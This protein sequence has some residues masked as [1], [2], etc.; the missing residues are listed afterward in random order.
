M[1]ICCIL[2]I[3]EL[4]WTELRREELGLPDFNTNT[5]FY[6]VHIREKLDG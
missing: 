6:W 5:N 1:F 2:E 3:L 4:S